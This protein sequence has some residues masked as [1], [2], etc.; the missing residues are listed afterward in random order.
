LHNYEQ[1]ESGDDDGSWGIPEDDPCCK[2]WIESDSKVSVSYP[3]SHWGWLSVEGGVDVSIEVHSDLKDSEEERP[4]CR[5]LVP[6]DCRFSLLIYFSL[7]C[8]STVGTSVGSVS[9][10]VP[11][12][13]LTRLS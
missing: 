2:E 11:V 7:L 8:H 13:E 6:I 10:L 5:L 12:E 3:T 9:S 4:T 1:F